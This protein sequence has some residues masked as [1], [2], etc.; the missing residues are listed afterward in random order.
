[1]IVAAGYGLLVIAAARVA[2]VDCRRL[3][4]EYESLSVL[5]SIAL[6]LTWAE[7]GLV[8][9]G[10]V[11]VIAALEIAVL[12]VMVRL[13]MIRRPGAGDWPLLAVC[14]VMA[15]DALVVFVAVMAV[16]GLAVAGIYSWNRRR[17]L[18]RSRFPLAP[19]ALLA[20]VM[21]FS[22]RHDVSGGFW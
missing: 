9:V 3:Q 2:W 22:V 6:A 11:L 18:L 10:R 7:G 8:A 19:P 21:A 4:I 15:A 14:L 1:M 20:A 16:S 5:S 17:P 12:A 13:A